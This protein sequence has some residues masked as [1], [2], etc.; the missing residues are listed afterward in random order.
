MKIYLASTLTEAHQGR[1][2]TK[3]NAFRR[4]LS[5]WF[6]KEKKHELVDYTKTGKKL[7]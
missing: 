5:Y 3:K 7:K 4:L 6:T 1:V 2:L